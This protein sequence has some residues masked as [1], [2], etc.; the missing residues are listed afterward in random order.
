MT[1]SASDPWPGSR[2]SATRQ[3]RE[4]L[5]ER[6]KDPDDPFRIVIVRDMWLTGFDAPSLHTIYVDKPMRGHGLMQAI[7]RVNRVWRDKPG[8]LVVDYIGLA[9]N[10]KAALRAYMHEGGPRAKPI[11]NEQLDVDVLI[12]ADAGEAGPLPD[13]SSTAST[14][15][16]SSPALPQSGWR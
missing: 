6:F 15:T 3:R 16:P 11:E 7:S 5:A 1:G 13:A 4:R 2:T 10:L 9:D 12:A 8:G 14:T